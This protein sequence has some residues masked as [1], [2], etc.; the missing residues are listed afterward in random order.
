M[1]DGRDPGRRYDGDSFVETSTWEGEVSGARTVG[2]AGAVAGATLPFTGFSV[3]WMSVIAAGLL[4]LG[5][6]LMTAARPERDRA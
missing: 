6:V 4:L 1:S 5:L 2:G 3:L